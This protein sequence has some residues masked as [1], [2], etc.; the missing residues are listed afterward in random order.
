MSGDLCSYE[1]FDIAKKYNCLLIIDEAHSSGVIGSKCLGIMDFYNIPYHKNFI[2]MGTLGKAYGSYGAYILA[3]REIII[4]LQNRAKSIIY[5][6]AISPFD[7]ALAHESFLYIQNNIKDIY[8]KILLFKNTIEK[9]LNIKQNSLIFPIKYNSNK[10]VLNM[11]KIIKQSN[12]LVG[13]IRT[14][15][16]KKPIIRITGN[17]DKI[18]YI[19]IISNLLRKT[20]NAK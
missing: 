3:S 2:K 13:A 12:I 9:E 6:T 1:F 18:K 16:V 17:I 7:I 14:P 5:S 8:N 11:Q 15:T 4:F 20:D 10:E 19:K